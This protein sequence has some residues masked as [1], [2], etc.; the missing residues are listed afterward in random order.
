MLN[1]FKKTTGM[2]NKTPIDIKT[3]IQTS[4]IEIYDKTKLV[5][6][7]KENFS[8]QDQKLYICNLFLF[9]NYH[10]INDYVIN[11]DNVW[12]FIGFSN[13]ANAKRLLKNNF[14]ENTDYKIVFIRSDENLNNYGSSVISSDENKVLLIRTDEQ[15]KDNRGGYNQEKIMLNINTF[16]KLCLKANTDNADKIHDYYIKLEMIYN[17]LMKE[18]LDLQKH[19]I[20]E[21]LIEHKEQIEQLQEKE[22]ELVK[23]KR[24]YEEIEKTQH[25]YVIK[26][27]GGIKIGKTKDVI[28]RIKGLQTGNVNDIETLL[29]FE[30]SNADILEKSVHYVLDRYR[31]NSN[32]EFFESNL[33]YIKLIVFILGNTLD[34][35]RSSFQDIKKE[36]LFSKLNEKMGTNYNV[37]TNCSTNCSTHCS[38]QEQQTLDNSS[39]AVNKFEKWLDK[40]VVEKKDNIVKLK[41]ICEKYLYK[42][43]KQQGHLPPKYTHTYRVEIENY[44]KNRFPNIKHEYKD[45]TFNG[46]RY[47]GWVGIALLDTNDYED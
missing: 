45:T 20:K 26:T 21:L 14:K 37:N 17:E 27:D 5:D 7:L 19:K 24:V 6:K 25:V 40:Y 44:I 9:L 12:K 28:K 30:T 3:L 29:D 4:N 1:I 34:T 35:L 39:T 42:Q 2:D 36:D 23:Y 10:Q 22:K 41:T 31:C 33:E 16:K 38:T 15:K 47:R 46:I 11:L 8:E 18:E 43:F 32:R 13:K